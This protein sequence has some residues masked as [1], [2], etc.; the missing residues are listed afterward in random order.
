M[1]FLYSPEATR[2]GYRILDGVFIFTRDSGYFEVTREY[3]TQK[4]NWWPLYTLLKLRGM[5]TVS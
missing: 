4:D 2:D 1:G 3:H 5:A